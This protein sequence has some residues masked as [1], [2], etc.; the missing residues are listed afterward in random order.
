MHPE[1]PR[2]SQGPGRKAIG[3]MADRPRP[4]ASMARP[5]LA[6]DAEGNVYV[7][8]T[9][10]RRL[11]RIDR[12][13]IITTVAGTTASAR[14]SQC[15]PWDTHMDC[16]AALVVDAEGNIFVNDGDDDRV[17]RIDPSGAVTQVPGTGEAPRP[18]RRRSVRHGGGLGWQRV[19]RRRRHITASG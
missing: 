14:S 6:A 1:Q 17:W 18:R 15:G 5:G 3:A 19:R 2:R 10:N 7:A 11:R 16:P 9:R 8:E 13:G 12:S 4:P